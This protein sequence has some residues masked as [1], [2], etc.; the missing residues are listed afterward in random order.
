ALSVIGL[1]LAVTFNV[2]AP[3]V[4]GAVAVAVAGLAHGYAHGQEATEGAFAFP[5]G[6]TLA[7]AALHGMGLTL[8]WAIRLANARPLARVAGLGVTAA[9]LAIA[10]AG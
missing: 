1:G 6:F 9:G 3:L 5:L 8:S 4:A 7:T 2:K 10:W